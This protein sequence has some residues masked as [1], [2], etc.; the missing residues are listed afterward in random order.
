MTLNIESL[1]S[2]MMNALFII[3]VSDR[4][5]YQQNRNRL[6]NIFYELHG[7]FDIEED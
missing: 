3:D 4:M 7:W 5:I 1:E 6:Y 2:Y